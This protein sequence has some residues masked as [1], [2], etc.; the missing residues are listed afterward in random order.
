MSGMSFA[1]K[2][3]IFFGFLARDLNEGNTLLP[4]LRPR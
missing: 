4:T 3:K 1:G 2:G